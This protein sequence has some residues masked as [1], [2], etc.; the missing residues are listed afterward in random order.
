VIGPAKRFGLMKKPEVS[1]EKIQIVEYIEAKEL[2]KP[3]W[4]EQ[5]HKK[6]ENEEKK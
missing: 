1:Q 3:V 2:E 6:S 5:N 4:F